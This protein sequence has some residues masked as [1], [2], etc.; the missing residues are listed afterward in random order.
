VVNML[1]WKGKEEITLRER[2]E[3]F[4]DQQA[5]LMSHGPFNLV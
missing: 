5:S 3:N 2:D 1:A 4:Q